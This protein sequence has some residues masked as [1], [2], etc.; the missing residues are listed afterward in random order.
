VSVIV[1]E[2]ADCIIENQAVDLAY[3]D[4][5]LQRVAQ[6]MA[7]CYKAGDDEAERAPDQ[8]IYAARLAV[9]GALN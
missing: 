6:G 2:G 3:G 4:D 7:Y 5:D 8:L 9:E 1:V